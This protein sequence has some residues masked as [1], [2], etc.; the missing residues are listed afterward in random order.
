[1]ACVSGLIL[2]V[3]IAASGCTGIIEGYTE[4][5]TR[6][7]STPY[8]RPPEEQ[9][10]VADYDELMAEMLELIIQ[11]EDSGSLLASNYDGDV[12]ADVARACSEISSDHPIGAYAVA[13]I[14]GETKRIVSIH[15][16][17][18]SIKYKRTKDQLDSLVNVATLRYLKTELQ[19]AMSNYRDEAV[20]RTSLNI[21]EED[22]I[23]F[24][25][26]AYYENPRTIVM[27]PVVAVETFPASGEDRI[28]E[29][30]FGNIEQ[31]GILR[32]YGMSLATRYVR[33]NAELA[34]GDTDAEILL[35]LANN[36]IASTSFDLG[37]AKAISVHGPQNFAATAYGALANGNAVGE[38]FA[39]AFK[40]LCDELGFDCRV[41]LGYLDGMVHA[42]NIVYLSRDFYH[43]DVAMCDANGIETAFLKNDADFGEHY[44][45][46]TENTVSCKGTMTYEDIVGVEEPDEESDDPEAGTGEEEN[47][48]SVD[49][50]DGTQDTPDGTQDETPEHPDNTGGETEG[51]PAGDE[52]P[53]EGP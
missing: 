51:P 32:Q 43:I 31:A 7:A 42:W 17:E 3:I 34:V 46:N 37:T 8:E 10:D 14:T 28:F 41:V 48:A 6:H 21:T 27:L 39:M 29:L 13:S 26:E 35:S 44:S 47:G 9:I 16:I 24:V 2:A 38:G 53:G 19:S 33:R 4:I 18:I 22:I 12:T 1:L 50:P 25:R 5:V 11:H 49:T 20:F 36:L 23:G 15:E 45:W 40:A 30:R 52:E